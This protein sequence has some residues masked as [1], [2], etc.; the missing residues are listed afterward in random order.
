MVE[1][2]IRGHV[3]Q[4][5]AKFFRSEVDPDFALSVDA[6]LSLELKTTLREIAP[7]SWYPRE[8]QVEMLRAVASAHGDEAATRRDLLLCGAG[9]AV[10]GNEFMKLLTK[11]L[12]PELFLKKASR[13]WVRDHQDSGGYHLERLDSD[14]HSASLRLR[15]VAGY[16]HSGL[17]WLGWMQAMFEEM[18]QGGAEI[19]QK[20]WTWSNP[21]PDE[22]VY[23]V[24]WS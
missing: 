16:A 10:G 2:M 19:D 18:G 20:G 21:A 22:V 4:H 12:T 3:I 1:P 15:G 11:V 14:R 24:K 7:A 17:L 8:L 5:T 9:M 13:F 6:A 23:E